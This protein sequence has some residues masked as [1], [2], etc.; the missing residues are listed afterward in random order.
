MPRRTVRALRD[1][2]AGARLAAPRR[3]APG[4]SRARSGSRDAPSWATHAH[5]AQSGS[6]RADTAG[7]ALPRAA[8]L[9][10]SNH[11]GPCHVPS[12]GAPLAHVSALV[13]AGPA[14]S[15]LHVQL[16]RAGAACSLTASR[17]GLR[18]WARDMRMRQPPENSRV[19]CCIMSLSK[20][21][22][23]HPPPTQTRTRTR[24][25]RHAQLARRDAS[26]SRLIQSIYARR[27][28][29]RRHASHTRRIRARA[30]GPA[31]AHGPARTSTGGVDLLREPRAAPLSRS[32]E[33]R[34]S[35]WTPARGFGA[36]SLNISV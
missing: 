33:R 28:I 16:G 32:R 1:D 29:C 3:A 17:R 23:A 4:P 12:E 8:P 31:Q 14:A 19:L 36:C 20:P 34:R 11:A 21:S 5:P 10:A 13:R 30:H 26:R 15:A 27:R 7:H 9:S 6:H 2:A 18:A 24:T 22:P 35:R 25:H